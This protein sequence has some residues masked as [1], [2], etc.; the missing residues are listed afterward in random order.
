MMIDSILHAVVSIAFRMRFDLEKKS[1]NV[2]VNER[3]FRR[4]IFA[5]VALT[6]F[7]R[8]F[9]LSSLCV[10]SLCIRPFCLT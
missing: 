10:T 1:R 3:R 5:D 8:G 4:D 2:N 7:L 6:C 9:R